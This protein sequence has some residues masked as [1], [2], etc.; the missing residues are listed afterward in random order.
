MSLSET[1]S[2]NNL[3]LVVDFLLNTS[4]T[5]TG[6]GMNITLFNTI[7]GVIVG[8]GWCRMFCN[9][10]FLTFGFWLYNLLNNKSI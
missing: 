5:K 4:K 7:K 6:L 2:Y 1:V 10:F 8:Q 3:C 9:Y